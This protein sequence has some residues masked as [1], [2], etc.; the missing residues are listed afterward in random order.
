MKKLLILL[1]ALATVMT[2]FACTGKKDNGGTTTSSGE[3]SETTPGS[4]ELSKEV[5]DTTYGGRDFR[6]SMTTGTNYEFYAEEDSTNPL[7]S[8]LYYRNLA[9]QDTADV[10]IYPVYAAKTTALY[11]HAD[12][13]VTAYYSEEDRYDITATTVVSSGRLITNN[14]LVDWNSLKYN[15]LGASW[16]LSGA[17]DAFSIFD[18][19]YTAVGTTNLSAL[20]H[21]Y[22]MMYNKTMGDSIDG[23]TESIYE[24]IDNKTWT[25][26]M[27]INVTK[28]IYSE[29]DT[30]PGIS[31]GDVFGFVAEDQTNLDVYNQAFG[32]QMLAPSDT[33]GFEFV[34]RSERLTTAVDKVLE[35]YYANSGSYIFHDAPGGEGHSFVQGKA[36][37]ATMRIE[38]AIGGGLDT[39][40]DVYTILPYPMLDESQGAYYSGLMDNY[41]VMGVYA[42]APDYD[43]CSH[44]V[45]LLNIEAEE[46][47]YP[48]YYDEALCKRYVQDERYVEMVDLVLAGR[49]FDAGTLFQDSLARVAMW[50]RDIIRAKENVIQG[51]LD[52]NEGKVKDAVASI[53]QSY[54]EKQGQTA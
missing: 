21:T 36:L 13:I 34:Y 49:R 18:S 14:T 31:A 46:Q 32:L 22:A 50:F 1:L 51:Y 54:L 33:E 28:N 23:L 9:V 48:A 3:G 39:M 4:T 27:L 26:D 53:V 29:D 41:T 7:L 45:E 12:E 15:D 17:N 43:F 8:A 20:R 16:W 19:I 25:I 24:A 35:L 42:L 5:P 52:A 6:I 30:I 47:L 10:V 38:T 37:F 2:A 44:I 11:D 40:E